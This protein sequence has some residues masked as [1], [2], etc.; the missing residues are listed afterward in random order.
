MERVDNRLWKIRCECG[1]VFIA[2]PSDSNGRC[3]ACGY[4]YLS[5]EHT[6]HGESPSHSRKATRLYTIWSNMR[7]RCNTPSRPDYAHYGGRGITVCDEWKNYVAFKEWALSNGYAD[8]LT[9]DRID[10]N[11]NYEP[12]NCRWATQSEQM[13]NTRVN[14]PITHNGET[15][16]MAEWSEKSGIPY[17][18]L[19]RRVNDY[20]F[21]AEEAL[22]LPP[23][24]GNNQTLRKSRRNTQK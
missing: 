2:Q 15:K 16:T 18:T 5:E 9:L 19:K 11:G 12:L 24:R 7:S 8:N 13:R 3:R 4:K 21:S 17:G 20:G 1:T 14:V 6:H 23:K 10:V 22:S